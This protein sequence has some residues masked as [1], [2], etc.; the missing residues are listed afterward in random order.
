MS[1]TILGVRLTLEG[2]DKVDADLHKLSSSFAQTGVSAAQTAA[3]M[4]Q[5]PAQF[6]DI[7][8]SLQAGQAPLTVLLQQGGQLKDAFGGVGNAARAMSTYLSSLATPINLTAAAVAAVGVAAYQGAQEMATWRNAMIASGNSVG[9]T[10]QQFQAVA[11]SMDSVAGITKGSATQAL[12]TFAST[13]KVASANLESFATSAIQWSR[14]T[15]D[16]I[17]DIAKN[18]A[19]L[20]KEPL[21]A[22]IKL[23]E[24]MNFL[25]LSV[26]QQ[27]KALDDQGKTV[28]A[29]NLAQR[30]YADTLGN[31]AAEME[32]NIGAIERS[33]RNVKAATLDAWDALKSLGRDPT[34]GERALPLMDRIGDLEKMK[35]FGLFW[36]EEREKS[37]QLAKA[38]LAELE[39]EFNAKNKIAA[40]DAARN[41][42][43]AARIQA[44]KDGLKYL[45]EEVKMRREIAQQLET[46]NAAGA[47]DAEKAKREADIRASY[48][49]KGPAASKEA[50]P[51]AADQEAAKEWAKYV[52]EFSKAAA[53]AEAKTE[54]LTKSQATL[55]EFLQSPG[56]ANMPE[57]ARQ[58]ALEK[59]YAAI[60]AEKQGEAE[61]VLAAQAKEAAKAYDDTYE[62][63]V[64][65]TDAIAGEAAKQREA[66]E[67]IGL[68]ASA[69]AALEA[70]RLE[71]QAV[72]KLDR[73][74]LADEID[75]SGKLGDAYREQASALRDLAKVKV[76]GAAA[77]GIAEAAKAAADEWKRTSESIERSITDSLMR[78][79][80][81]GKGFARNMRDTLVNL[82]KTLVL[83]PVISFIVNPVAAAITGSMGLS[84]AA[85][86]AGTVNAVTTG[87]SLLSGSGYVS[88]AQSIFNGGSRLFDMGLETMGQ[89]MMDIGNWAARNATS[90]ETFGNGLGY[91]SAAISAFKGNWG[92]AAGAAIGTYLGGPIGATLGNFLGGLI[93]SAFAGESRSGGQYGVAY[94]GQV[95]NNRR[96]ET[97]QYVGQQFNRDNSTGVR[98]TN[99]KSYL[100]EADGLGATADAAINK[101]VAGAAETIDKTLAA[102]G[103]KLQTTG[104]W[105]G[106][107]TSGKGRGGVFAGGSLT[108]G[109]GFGESGKGDN[110]AGTLYEKWSTQSPDAATA[111]A[112]F[113]LDLK[114]SVVQALQAAT[115]IPTTI[116]TMLTD[117]AGKLLEVESM[118]AEQVD[119]LL[120]SIDNQIIAVQTLQQVADML[121]LQNLKKLSFDASSELIKLAGGLDTLTSQAQSYYQNF[122]SASEQTDNTLGNIK[123]S[124]KSV[125]LELPTTR[126]G[127]RALVEAQ[128]LN[129]ESGRKAYAALMAV[130]SAFAS[131]T[132]AAEGAAKRTAADIK[133]EK[134]NLQDQLDQ[135]TMSNT[136]LLKKQREALDESN[137]AIFDQIQAEKKA[138]SV[139][140]ERTGLQDQLDQ[141]T[142]TNAQL[143]EKQRAALDESNRA[144]FDQIQAEKKAASVKAERTNLQDQLDQLTL[145]NAELLA[146][147]RAALDESNRAI[148]DQI[149][150]EKKAAEVKSQRASLQD[151]Y[152]QLTMTSAQLLDKQRNALDESNRALF[153]QVQAQKK[154]NAVASERASLQTQLDQALGNTAALRAAE[155][156][157][158]D[159]SNR[160]LQERIWAIADARAAADAAYSAL[161]ASINKQRTALQQTASIAQEAVSTIG[162]IYETLKSNVA[163]LYNSVAS[164]QGQGKAAALDFIDQV[165]TGAQATGS[166]P[167]GQAL[168]DAIAAARNGLSDSNT[169]ASAFEQQRAQL[170]L[171]GKLADLQTIAGVQK[172]VAQQQLDAAND[173]LSKL[174]DTLAYWKQQLDI[175]NGTYKATLSVADAIKD[176]SAAILKVNAATGTGS[177]STSSGSAGSTSGGTS[178]GFSAGPGSGSAPTALTGEEANLA[179]I[180]GYFLATYDLSNR[181]GSL[182]KIA[183]TAKEYNVTQARLAK[184]VGWN[185]DEM[186]RLFASAGIPAFAVGTNFVP[187]DMLAMIHQGEAIVPKAYNPAANGV[188][189][190]DGQVAQ[191]L[192]ALVA[193]AEAAEA[194]LA[195]LG[196]QLAELNNHAKRT[197]DATNGNAEG[198]PQRVRIVGGA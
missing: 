180:R 9:A 121:P 36:N 109:V 179:S 177:G 71:E 146:K 81:S 58:L 3:A 105:A 86:A 156:A 66:N 6:T 89:G 141:L 190:S 46:L 139:K 55:V 80:E 129:T 4:R 27:I 43:V 166:L 17:S 184:A 174:D 98:V 195:A 1:I 128:D 72:A 110:T 196:G 148:F 24:G 149:Q 57:S 85:N 21:S 176:L 20:A 132:P 115:D 103:S 171:A 152:D 77:K 142:L 5:V 135:L 159:E 95:A 178:G 34:I 23:N 40:A 126:D 140:A 25:T 197:A 93:D 33:W 164:T 104:Y 151:E 29:A 163:D 84:T 181:A 144:I 120:K 64:K 15:G 119:A 37:L 76:D 11:D 62:S 13:G 10:V 131:V 83:R 32:K 186:Q 154:A 53:D 192:S 153:D 175:S 51:F 19:D 35:A 157:K 147:Q 68:S 8:T 191:L 182:A 118:T 38:E 42:S 188:L 145:T 61:K 133:S 54:G 31:R 170:V 39:K 45:S 150:A 41:T 187:R 173:Q 167:D 59:A 47:S 112:N 136:D 63:I 22:T 90:L 123:T 108:G 14:E 75:W 161:E 87:S 172:S 56:Y 70:A 114:Q 168:T 48:N 198:G 12:V 97:Y 169:F 92:A 67:A 193:R 99:G 7:V 96:G 79:F 78:G 30:T 185:E 102:L 125:G 160:A 50:N 189:Q 2:A 88:G 165:L 127:F 65:R 74:R 73:A 28:E 91:A 16:S 69:I 44:D 101:A 117:D 116:K 100:M 134:G 158:L 137:R 124:L 183:Q 111:M 49:K 52:Q 107:E 122:Y 130:S 155:L 94:N 106:L 194:Q 18:F 82:F 26:Y 113:T 162:S 138:Q 143:L 60:A